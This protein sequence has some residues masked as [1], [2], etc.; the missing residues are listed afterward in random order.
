VITELS[1]HLVHL[2]CD[3]RTIWPFSAPVVW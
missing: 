3:N 1:G 2:L